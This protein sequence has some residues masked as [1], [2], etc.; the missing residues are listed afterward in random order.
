MTI[1]RFFQDGGRPPLWIC[2]VCVLEGHFVVFIAVQ[3]LVGIDAVVLIICMF[4]DFSS[5]TGKRLL[6]PPKLGFLGDLTP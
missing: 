4:F 1:F 3:N 6:T 5:L 2:Y